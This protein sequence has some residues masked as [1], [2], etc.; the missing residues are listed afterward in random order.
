M[1]TK[2]NIIHLSNSYLHI[3]HEGEKLRIP[4]SDVLKSSKFTREYLPKAVRNCLANASDVLLDG[5]A[6]SHD[7]W[8]DTPLKENV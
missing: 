2:E 7:I 4:L 5:Y 6:K 8:A 3:T 1:K